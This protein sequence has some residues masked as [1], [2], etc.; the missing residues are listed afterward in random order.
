MALK[1]YNLQPDTATLGA[2]QRVL[3][4]SPRNWLGT[5]AGDYRGAAFATDDRLVALS[6][7]R[8]DQWDL[9]SCDDH[10]VHRAVRHPDHDG[11]SADGTTIVVGYQDGQWETR[12]TGSL[13]RVRDRRKRRRLGDRPGR[14]L[15]RSQHRCRRQIRGRQR[16]LLDHRSPPLSTGSNHRSAG[17]GR[18]PGLLARRHVARRRH[19]DVRHS[20]CVRY[21]DRRGGRARAVDRRSQPRRRQR[22]VLAR[23]GSVD[24]QLRFRSALR[25]PHRY[26]TDCRSRHRRQ[27]QQSRDGPIPRRIGVPLRLGRKTPP[28]RRWRRPARIARRG[29]PIS[30]Q[31]DARRQPQRISC[32]AGR[33]H[34]HL[35]VV[36]R[37]SRNARQAGSRHGGSE[38]R[39]QRGWPHRRSPPTRSR[40][41]SW[42]GTSPNRRNLPRTSPRT[43]IS[44][45]GTTFSS[46]CTP[47][48]LE[49]SLVPS[50]KTGSSHRWM[51][52]WRKTYPSPRSACRRTAP[53]R[54][55]R[56]TAASAR[57]GHRLAPGETAR[58]PPR[59]PGGGPA[60]TYWAIRV[61]PGIHARRLDP[62]RRRP[63]RNRV[64]STTPP[65]GPKRETPYHPTPGSTAS[66]SPP[67]E[68]AP[69]LSTGPAAS[70]RSATRTP[71]RYST[72]P[73]P[74]TWS[75]RWP[76]PR[77]PRRRPLC[78]HG[79]C[80]R[81]RHPV[82]P[83]QPRARRR[84]VPPSHRLSSACGG[85]HRRPAR[86]GARRCHRLVGCER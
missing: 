32:R 66:T 53:L 80:R 74:T 46:W 8:L 50:G 39:A 84:S 22:R 1:A 79:R 31:P 81:R 36:D 12:S 11:R 14:L 19:R 62:S 2:V 82:G 25:S 68:P 69:S 55:S 86:D 52:S 7:S 75:S 47:T 72:R 63:Q 83:R 26:L 76:D 45:T 61:G 64:T 13:G 78:R 24:R 4:R 42:F 48:V 15:R 33:H 56:P 44:S 28:S 27:L 34:R 40:A 21:R 23:P 65:P 29:S 58:R 60:P 51:P 70:S 85:G 38:G 49:D 3:L 41:R 17:R 18:Q 35:A 9:T 77:H 43:D 67:T 57:S 20:H 54:S 6:A 16:A 73:R 71:S 59:D 10:R 30:H 5:L 37:W